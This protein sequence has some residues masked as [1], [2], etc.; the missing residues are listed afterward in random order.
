M[1]A[2]YS[3]L[4]QSLTS[5]L[6][7]TLLAGCGSDGGT[8]ET[9]TIIVPQPSV[10][11][12]TLVVNNQVNIK[13]K[14]EKGL[15]IYIDGKNS[16]IK[17][18]NDGVAT[19]TLDSSNKGNGEIKF[20][21]SLVDDKGNMS[22]PTVIKITRENNTTPSIVKDTIKPVIKLNGNKTITLILNTPYHE[23][24]AKAIDN[25][26]G[27]VKVTSSGAVDVLKL[28]TYTI[29]Y[30]AIDKAG[31]R[32]IVT[33]VITVIK[34]PIVA[35]RVAPIITIIGENPISIVQNSTYKDLG[36]TAKDDKDENIVVKANSNVKTSNLGEYTITY[37]A[38]DKAG[39]KSTATRVV[40][41]VLPADIVA[42]VITIVGDNPLTIT[43]GETFSDKGATA[44][45]NRDGTV[46]VTPT[47]N[48]DMD[49]EGTYTVVYT[50]TDKAGNKA[51]ATRT[52]IVKPADVVWNVSTVTEF[53]Q[54]LEDASANGENDTIVLAK[55]VY[56]TTSDGLGTFK[57]NDNEEFN[58]T[59]KA[60]EGLT[61]KDVVLDGNNSN[62]IFNFNNIV[63]NYH[64]VDISTLVLKNIS[65]INGKSKKGEQTAGVY[66]S[67][68]IEIYNSKFSFN[69]SFNNMYPSAFRANKAKVI[70][71]TISHNASIGFSVNT[72]T[73]IDSNISN[74]E[75]VGFNTVFATIKNSIF[76]NNGYGFSS[77]GTT[78]V[79]KSIFSDNK[80]AINQNTGNLTVSNSII[81]NGG[82]IEF[83]GSTL[84][85]TNSIFLENKGY[86][87]KSWGSYSYISNN[88]LFGNTDPI[89][90]AG[91]IFVNNILVK[92]D[93]SLDLYR[94]SKLYNNYIDYSKIKDNQKNI[95]K[96]NN[97]QPS[98]VGDVYLSDDNKTLTED[99][100]VIDKGLNPSS[101]TY[102]KIIDNDAVY[103]Q[104]LELLKT[105]MIGN[106]RVY[107]GTIDM[108]AIEYGS[109]R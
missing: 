19:L 30:T 107:N 16:N 96:K 15:L 93:S 20:E 4:K 28:G 12:P 38:T 105:D 51:T 50:A 57:F 100:P 11:A 45:D 66:C 13:V 90:L 104:L 95:I 17:I 27:V 79:K 85:I 64:S 65:V 103:K 106:K 67:H 74:H 2:K 56:N 62:Q 70:N 32:T 84:I 25:I 26:D 31:N 98:S 61:Y 88:T 29:T 22:Q 91:T 80:G 34:K 83:G 44:K 73:L 24:G 6:L 47:S 8:K 58:L 36:A 49:E 1:K 37:T 33:R 5:L 69:M 68:N 55:G 78:I 14:G 10:T 60:E 89:I 77:D 71:S 7:I 54:A 97:L 9:T 81:S 94:N 75:H 72:V 87:I 53:R 86:P 46:T 3:R 52:V 23:L 92:N 102:K 35:D 59:I 48:V 18:G 42:P 40:K 63:F 41:V 99:S 43:Q 21:I 108:G 39:N 101:A 76:K 82:G 109:S